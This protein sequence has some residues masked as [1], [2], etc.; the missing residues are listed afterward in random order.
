MFWRS[1]KLIPAKSL[2][3]CHSRKFIPAKYNFHGSYRNIDQNHQKWRQNKTIS[4][5]FHVIAKV[6]TR[7]IS[8]RVF[9]WKVIPA[10]INCFDDRTTYRILFRLL[11]HAHSYDI[12]SQFL[13]SC[14]RDLRPPCSKAFSTI[15]CSLSYNWVESTMAID[16]RLNTRPSCR[17]RSPHLCRFCADTQCPIRH[18][19]RFPRVQKCNF[20]RELDMGIV[21]VLKC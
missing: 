9:Q 1:R 6:Y 21:W 11:H 2:V 12:P 3:Q 5:K 8:E 14:P 18:H 20:H 4:P 13:Y 19:G 16:F 17:E 7:I 15:S 10:K